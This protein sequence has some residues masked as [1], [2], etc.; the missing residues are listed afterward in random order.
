MTVII[1]VLGSVVV[2]LVI[3]SV[4]A[5]SQAVDCYRRAQAQAKLDWAPVPHLIAKYTRME[6][7]AKMWFRVLL[8]WLC[9]L[10][11]VAV[12]GGGLFMGPVVARQQQA[13]QL[14]ADASS[15]R[16][17]QYEGTPAEREMASELARMCEDRAREVDL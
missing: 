13:E 11:A 2:Y 14:R 10:I 6:F 17:K 3:G 7:R 5:R 8:W 15:W 12:K 16:S 1:V 4:Y 9:P